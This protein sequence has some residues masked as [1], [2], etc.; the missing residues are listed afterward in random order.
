MPFSNT[1]ET[2]VLKYAFNAN[3]V[4]R[5]TA[6][7]LGLFA[8]DPSSGTEISGN[9][10]VRKAITFVVNGNTAT[11]SDVVEFPIADGNWGTVSHVAIFDAATSGNQIGYA[12]L[13][14]PRQIGL[15]DQLRFST[16][17]VSVTLS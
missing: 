11:N 2:I 8:S 14:A 3:T 9:G 1:Y 13:T 4:T 12:E 10:Y 6:W 16:S 17:D 5:P 15:D 7:Y